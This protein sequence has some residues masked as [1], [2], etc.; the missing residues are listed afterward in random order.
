[1]GQRSAVASSVVPGTVE[2]ISSH[3]GEKACEEKAPEGDGQSRAEREQED[4]NHCL[5]RMAGGAPVELRPP[6]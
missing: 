3:E 6:P 4:K 5:A 2:S 1:M